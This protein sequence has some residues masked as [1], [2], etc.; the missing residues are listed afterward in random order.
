MSFKPKDATEFSVPLLQPSKGLCAGSS[1]GLARRCPPPTSLLGE[2]TV[3]KRTKQARET[4]LTAGHCHRVLTAR[5]SVRGASGQTRTEE[6]QALPPP[7]PRALG[8]N[9]RPQ[10][11][12]P[13]PPPREA[14][15]G[16]I[17][18]AT[19][20]RLPGT[21]PS[22]ASGQAAVQSQTP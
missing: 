4:Q 9:R 17:P 8:D 13:P 19:P 18:T 12:A 1:E 2:D 15:E 16:A 21:H 3:P 22:G 7:A 20:K 5:P 10:G 14:N 11:R 6:K